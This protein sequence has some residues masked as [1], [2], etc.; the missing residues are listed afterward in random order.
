MEGEVTPRR[1]SSKINEELQGYY[2]IPLILNSTWNIFVW[3]FFTLVFVLNPQ[4]NIL[5]IMLVYIFMII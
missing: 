5:E 1:Y 2:I 3:L 4:Y